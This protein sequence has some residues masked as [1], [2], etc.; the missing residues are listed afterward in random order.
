MYE[1][2]NGV[3]FDNNDY[4]EIQFRDY[5]KNFNEIIDDVCFGND[6]TKKNYTLIQYN[7]QRF[8]QI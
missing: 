5:G 6:Y 3:F 2:P 1:D 7:C 8:C 4:V